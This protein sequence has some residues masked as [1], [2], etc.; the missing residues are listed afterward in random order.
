MTLHWTRDQIITHQDVGG[1]QCRSTLHE[2]LALGAGNGGADL[3]ALR[4]DRAAV[5][6]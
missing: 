4:L 5:H 2:Q 1:N 6:G 3:K